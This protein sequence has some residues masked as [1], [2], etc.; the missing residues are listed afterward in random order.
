MKTEEATLSSGFENIQPGVSLNE[1]DARTTADAMLAAGIPAETVNAEL[2]KLGYGPVDA[3]VQATASRDLAALKSS[4]EWVVKFNAGDPAATEQF[5]KLTAAMTFGA[6]ADTPLVRAE[7][8]RLPAHHPVLAAHDTATRE[9]F[10]SETAAWATELQLQPKVAEA[11][12]EYALDAVAKTAGM[13]PDQKEA[14]GRNEEAMFARVVNDDKAIEDANRWLDAQM[15]TG[16]Q[17][18]DLKQIARERGASLANELFLHAAYL[19]ETSD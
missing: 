12:A 2:A 18:F 14:W 3:S 15:P 17:K 16:T 4:P 9:R 5:N 6:K 19:A 11:I 1:K 10:Q 7:E 13:A 8:Y